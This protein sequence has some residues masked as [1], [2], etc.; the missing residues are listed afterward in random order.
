[1]CV[2][3]LIESVIVLTRKEPSTTAGQL[4]SIYV[5]SRSAGLPYMY[6]L[7]SEHAST[8]RNRDS[9]SGQLMM[10]VKHYL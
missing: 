9:V 10:L 8:V 7:L 3:V 5:L 4:A 6:V 2:C 1:V